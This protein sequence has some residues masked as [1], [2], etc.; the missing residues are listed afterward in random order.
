MADDI[1]DHPDLRGPEWDRLAREAAR[2]TRVPK[3]PRRRS[4]FWAAHRR[5][6]V[7]GVV[8]LGVAGGVLLGAVDRGAV[9]S[10]GTGPGGGSV[11]ATSA[12]RV[13]VRRVDLAQ[14]FAGTPAAGWADGA[15]GIVVPVATP[16]GGFTAEQV[17]AATGA[18]YR[19]VVAAHLDAEVTHGRGLDGYWA[20]FAPD[21][22][23]YVRTDGPRTNLTPEHRLLDVP[24]KVSGTMTVAAGEPGELVVHTNYAFA[25]AFTP[26]DPV[27]VTGPMDIV[28]VLRVEADYVVRDRSQ[29]TATSAGLW[30]ET[31]TGHG[32]AVDCSAF[33]RGEIAPAFTERSV[34]ASEVDDDVE[35][36]SFDPALPMPTTSNCPAP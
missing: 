6:V 11:V 24:V 1:F 5:K 21:G 9:D 15:A 34:T 36:A 18:V 13:E 25:Y 16:V 2:R 30:L 7:A 33:A 19:A 27:A 31:W 26:D 28:S 14:P 12:T 10:S 29:F 17:S 8:V 23:E 20:M 22:R 4:V 32:Y 35:A 3:R